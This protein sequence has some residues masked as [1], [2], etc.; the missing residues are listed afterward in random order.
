MKKENGFTLVELLAVIVILGVLLTFATVNVIGVMNSSR[1]KVGNFTKEQIEDAAKTFAVDYT[2]CDGI[3]DICKVIDNT[4]NLLELDF[5][6]TKENILKYL[7]PYYEEMA[8]KCNIGDNAKI[9]IHSNV[10]DIK[11]DIS[12]I[13]CEK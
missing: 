1:E 2:S 5:T 7:G 4:N 3:T 12:D 6:L 9:V 11:V 8:D 13:K 10:D